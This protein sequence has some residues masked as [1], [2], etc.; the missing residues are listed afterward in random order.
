MSE[1]DLI[2]RQAAIDELDK[3]AWG[4]EWDKALAKAMIESLP[5]AQPRG[6]WIEIE[7][8]DDSRYMKCDQCKT[9]QVFYY[10]KRNT[11]FCPHCGAKMEVT[12]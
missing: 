10:G 12:E 3:G 6:K 9:V 4:V 5:S 11:N 2:S 1:T 8:F 7:A